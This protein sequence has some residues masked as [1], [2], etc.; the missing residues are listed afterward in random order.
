MASNIQTF[1]FASKKWW[2]TKTIIKVF[3]FNLTSPYYKL[4]KLFLSLL[5]WIREIWASNKDIWVW[6][7]I[8]PRS[9]CTG[10]V[11]AP[12][13]PFHIHFPSTITAIARKFL[14]IK[15]HIIWI[16]NFEKESEWKQ[17]HQS[18]TTLKC[19]FCYCLSLSTVRRKYASS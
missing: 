6:V 7:R 5:Y 3:I 13:V 14:Y 16:Q 2:N 15:K 18:I 17:I 4:M 1:A 9:S 12:D 19:H 8:K 11:C 10:A